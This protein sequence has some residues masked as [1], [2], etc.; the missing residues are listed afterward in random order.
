MMLF[1][2]ISTFELMNW[3]LIAHHVS[4]ILGENS[5]YHLIAVSFVSSVDNSIALS[6][7][8]ALAETQ[9]N[10]ISFKILFISFQL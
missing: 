4:Y 3:D 10:P 8:L 7:K 9:C 1:I 6:T 2:T 5:I